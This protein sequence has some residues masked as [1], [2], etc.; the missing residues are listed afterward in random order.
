MGQHETAQ[1][2]MDPKGRRFAVDVLER[3]VKGA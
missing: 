3:Y 2:G 1:I